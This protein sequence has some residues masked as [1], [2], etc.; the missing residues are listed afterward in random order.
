LCGLDVLVGFFVWLFVW[1]SGCRVRLLWLCVVFVALVGGD[2][3]VHSSVRGV[4]LLGSVLRCVFFVRVLCFCGLFVLMC[5]D[6]VCV[7]RVF[8]LF[9]V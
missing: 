1:G 2:L 3:F 9:D 6:V 7:L 5:D 8:V 4:C